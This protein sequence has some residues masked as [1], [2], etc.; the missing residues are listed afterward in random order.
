VSHSQ[1][2][3]I[4]AHESLGGL[5]R[6]L[7]GIGDFFAR[8]RHL[9]AVRDGVVGALPLVLTGSIFLLLAQ[10][11]SAMLQAW[12]A[13][14]TPLLLVPFRMLG[15]L[16]A[17]YVTYGAAYSLSRSYQLDARA[18]GLLAMAAYLIAAMPT[19]AAGAPPALP[20][21]RLGAGGIFAGFLIAFGS[22]E[23][24]RLFVRRQWTLRLPSSA[25]EAV[26]KSFTALIPA[27]AVVSITFVVVHVLN[28][29]LVSLLEQAARPFVKATSSL[30]AALGVVG[31]DSGLWLL[32]VHAS[33][34]ISTL[35]PLWESMLIENATGHTAGLSPLPHIAPLPFYQW[36]IW[37]GG[38]GTTLAL[39]LLL[40]RAKSAQ[41][42]GVGKQ[43]GRA[44]V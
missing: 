9:S 14:Y 44:H 37:Q 35:R 20:L 8:Q 36:F 24:T 6:W 26:V 43:I 3:S 13:P 29:D 15:G 18:S 39:T 1:E 4:A 17:L 10:P 25:P 33:A 38:S 7:Q 40:L 23:L 28:V 41:L 30:P 22:V 2:S 27:M 31:I 5:R 21:A 16:V 32:G 11:P 42:K 19:P 34:A 12:V